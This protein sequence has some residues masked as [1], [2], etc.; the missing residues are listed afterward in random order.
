M[1]MPY[2]G[3][4][5][6][7]VERTLVRPTEEALATLP[8]IRNIQSTATANGANI[9]VL[10]SDWERDVKIAASEARE[11]IDAIRNDLPDEL[12]RIF[13]G[14]ASTDDEPVLAIRLA[15]QTLDL[16]KSFGLERPEGALS[17]PRTPGCQ[18]W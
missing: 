6:E 3:S 5:P 12:T 16:S 14:N 15:S 9:M 4:T 11:R 1:Q 17:R 13:V 10:F 2:Q 18:T 7:E 8:G